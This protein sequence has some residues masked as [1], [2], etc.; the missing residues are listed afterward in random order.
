MGKVCKRK[1]T[2]PSKLCF[3]Y[4]MCINIIII[5]HCPV[6]YQY[7]IKR[8]SKGVSNNYYMLLMIAINTGTSISDILSTKNLCIY[9]LLGI[10]PHACIFFLYISCWKTLI[11]CA[12]ILKITSIVVYIIGH[13]SKTL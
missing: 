3:F 12:F 11:I 8:N 6:V 13:C 1:F 9:V 10:L 2:M 4:C 7:S 5:V